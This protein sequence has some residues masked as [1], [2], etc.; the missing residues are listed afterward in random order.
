MEAMD[1][2]RA[3]ATAAGLLLAGWLAGCFGL[4]N[5][6]QL[7]GHWWQVLTAWTMHAS[8]THLILN[9]APLVAVLMFTRR[10]W[11]AF[12]VAAAGG[13]AG[14]A[15]MLLAGHTPA[16]GA[17]G[18]VC[19]GI[20]LLLVEGPVAGSVLW[21]RFAAGLWLAV[22]LANGPALPGHLTGLVVGLVASGVCWLVGCRPVAA[23]VDGLESALAA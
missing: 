13:V 17:S 5:M 21:I 2:V 16:L 23:R 20:G 3:T 6:L 4:L 19:A 10:P 1:R 8:F 7:N 15:A 12:A 22:L 18:A 14:D 11:W 9:L